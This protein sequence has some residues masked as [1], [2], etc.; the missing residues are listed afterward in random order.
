MPLVIGIV[1]GIFITVAFAAVGAPA[2][3][4][5]LIGGIIAGIIGSCAQRAEQTE[6]N[7][8]RSSQPVRQPRTITINEDG[9]HTCD[10][11]SVPQH[12]PRGV[13]LP[14]EQLRRIA[15]ERGLTLESKR[16]PTC[17]LEIFHLSGLPPAQIQSVIQNS[18]KLLR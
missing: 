15:Q 3:P 5:G 10:H 11:A 18:N 17:G 16:C 6:Q 12:N 1:M 7:A 2:A 13:A 4:L 14:S 8:P 9:S